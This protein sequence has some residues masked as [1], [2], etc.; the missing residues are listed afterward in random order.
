MTGMPLADVRLHRQADVGERLELG[1]PGPDRT[2]RGAVPDGRHLGAAPQGGD[3][4]VRLDRPGPL[5]GAVDRDDPGGVA[6][7]VVQVAGNGPGLDG[8]GAAD[9]E[10][11]EE[12]AQDGGVLVLEPGLVLPSE[13][14]VGAD[15][16]AHPPS[17]ACRS[18]SLQ[19][20]ATVPSAETTA[21]LGPPVNG[22]GPASIGGT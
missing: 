17:A 7:G 14:L 19:T 3:L 22:E 6:E 8:D 16:A 21:V 18:S 15:L 20:S 10:L 13:A 2:G 11:A 4:G 9:A 5:Q 1:A 12:V